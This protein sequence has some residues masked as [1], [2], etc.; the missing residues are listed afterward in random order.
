M[1]WCAYKHSVVLC[2]IEVS[3]FPVEC[4]SLFFEEKGI[5]N[6]VNAILCSECNL[7]FILW[8][9]EAN[10]LSC[11]QASIDTQP[12]IVVQLFIVISLKK[13]VNERST[14]ISCLI[15]NSALFVSL[16]FVC[17]C[18]TH[19]RDMSLLACVWFVW[20]NKWN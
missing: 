19:K 4:I 1:M 9:E 16:N 5:S 7:T 17:N 11:K 10:L 18:N 8:S 3:L 20:L 15:L 12:W 13:V 14:R 6:N 2:K